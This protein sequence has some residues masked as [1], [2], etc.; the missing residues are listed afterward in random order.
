MLLED[1]KQT[2]LA[3]T[4]L[5]IGHTAEAVPETIDWEAL[6]DIAL[7]QGLLAVVLD[8]AQVLL[9]RGE[10]TGGRAI[11][12]PVRKQWVGSVIQNYEQK[13]ADYRRR[14]GQLAGFYNEHGFK[15]MV[16]KGYGLSLNYPVPEHRPCGD[17]DIWAFGQYREADAAIEKE[18]GIPIDKTH[19]HHTVFT[20]QGYSVENHYDFV[21]VHGHRS[22][23]KIEKI[24]KQLAELDECFTVIDGEK[25]YLPS[26]DLSALFLLRHT[27]S[28]F[29]STSMN[30]RQILDWAFFVEKNT[31]S[32]HWDWLQDVLEQFHMTDFFRC[33]N[34]ICVEDLGFESSIFP[35]NSFS[36]ALKQRVLADTLSPEFDEPAPSGCLK[37]FIFKYRR[38]RA[39]NWKHRMCYKEGLM[40][41]FITL[42]WSHIVGPGA[43]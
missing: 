43:D 13:Y 11:P 22:S 9:D 17:I 2:L 3:L 42:G 32:I 40:E 37:S 21:N 10:L 5:G 38:W 30:L 8:G 25:V 31:G 23:A 34:A 27:M 19:H 33:M 14:L 36:S 41:S 1:R 15:L 26:P 16:L 7:R 4:R 39:N 35:P 24:F 20:F 6:M 28:H 18:L 12:V 29:A